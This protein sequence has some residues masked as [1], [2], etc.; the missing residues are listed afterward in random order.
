MG[1]TLMDLGTDEAETEEQ[2]VEAQQGQG[3]VQEGTSDTPV[4]PEGDRPDFIPEKFWDPESHQP[5]LEE[6]AKSQRDF[7]TKYRN[8]EGTKVEDPGDYEYS[9]PEGSEHLLIAGEDGEEDPLITGYRD[10]AHKSGMSAEMFQA[11][12][13]WY[14]KSGSELAPQ[15]DPAA[16]VEAMG[17]QGQAK[18]NML[19]A[20]TR[21]LVDSGVLTDEEQATF[22]DMW[23]DA[24]SATVMHKI[25]SSMGEQS[26]PNFESDSSKVSDIELDSMY[27]ETYEDG[28]Y[29]GQRKYAVDSNF[30]AKVDKLYA[31]RYGNDPGRT[32][33]PIGGSS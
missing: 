18:V 27:Q 4:S 14:L 17:P 33:V 23:N 15:M 28:P 13:E 10:F 11:S 7:E 9:V 24:A 19:S 29:K 20:K 1:A 8:R 16:E 31:K 12:I 32:S 5:R 30:K 21:Q 22:I 25:L 3:D 6:L 2:P 26:I